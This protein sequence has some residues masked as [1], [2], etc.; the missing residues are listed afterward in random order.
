MKMKAIVFEKY[1]TPEDVLELQEVEKPTIN[2]NEVLVKVH[3]ATVNYADWAYVRGKPFMIRLGQG[4]LKPKYRIPG[5]D[6][7]GQVEDIGRN[8]KQFQPGDEVFGTLGDCGFGA[9]AEYASVPLYKTQDLSSK[10]TNMTFF[11]M[12]NMSYM[13]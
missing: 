5:C 6:I 3:A 8:V 1:G 7:A 2:N 4:L 11:S 13:P 10:P 12:C 9:Y